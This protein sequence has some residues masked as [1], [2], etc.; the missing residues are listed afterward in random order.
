[1]TMI[2]IPVYVPRE[3]ERQ[4][5]DGWDPMAQAFKHWPLLSGRPSIMISKFEF[6]KKRPYI[7]FFVEL[8]GE[9]G[10]VNILQKL[11]EYN[12]KVDLLKSFSEKII[13]TTYIFEDQL[14]SGSIERI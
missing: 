11:T 8:E 13:N 4:G 6:L 9:F 14:I 1:M 2:F 3:G 10:F 12:F 7:D 5:V